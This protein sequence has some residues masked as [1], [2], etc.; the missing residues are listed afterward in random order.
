MVWANVG[1]GKSLLSFVLAEMHRL[2]TGYSSYFTAPVEKP[3]VTEDGEWLYV[4]HKVIDLK[5]YYQK[6]KKI[7]NFN[8]DKY[9]IIFKD[10]RHLDYTPRMNKT[11][12][13][14]DTFVP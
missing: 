7:L 13:Y 1:G 2:E 12:E 9:R 11:K 5:S 8:T 14:N 4:Y 3:Q 10:E 6:G